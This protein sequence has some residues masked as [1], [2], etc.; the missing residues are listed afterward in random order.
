VKEQF[1]AKADYID[2]SSS[3]LKPAPIHPVKILYLLN[4]QR[5]IFKI[6]LTQ[7]INSKNIIILKTIKTTLY[8]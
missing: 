2:L 5:K 6:K 8:N 7:I 3:G 1:L 4:N